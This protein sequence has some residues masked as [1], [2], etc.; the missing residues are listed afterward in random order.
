V[1]WLREATAGGTGPLERVRLGSLEPL[2]R[3][4][5]TLAAVLALEPDLVV[6]DDADLGLDEPGRAG[7][8]AVCARVCSGRD[9]TVVLV[10][11]HAPAYLEASSRE[12]A[13]AQHAPADQQA[14]REDARPAP[15]EPQQAGAQHADPPHADLQ[16]PE[17][18][19]VEADG[20]EDGGDAVAPPG[21]A[22]VRAR[23]VPPPVP[24]HDAERADERTDARADELTDDLTE[25][26]TR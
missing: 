12:P 7:L 21:P 23:A 26:V 22:S 24:A 16:P 17:L 15:A 1:G 19:P 9:L 6:V 11:E 8:A 5:V 2:P 3:R 13:P 4:L 18:E 10:G 20:Q 25:E 14:A